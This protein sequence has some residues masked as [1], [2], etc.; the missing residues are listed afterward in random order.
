MNL[1][2]ILEIN[3]EAINRIFKI[4]SSNLSCSITFLRVEAPSGKQWK[5][6]LPALEWERNDVEGGEGSNNKRRVV[7]GKFVH[8]K[9]Y[10]TLKIEPSTRNSL[11]RALEKFIASCGI[12]LRTK[13]LSRLM[14]LSVCPRKRKFPPWK[15]SLYSSPFL[16]SCS[17]EL[18]DLLKVI[19]WI[20]Y[21]TET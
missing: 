9:S 13:A 19:R 12:S 1:N 18:A 7:A 6:S 14:F 21:F 3:L 5:F 15:F 11:K 20:Y 16:C 2:K 10:P 4:S 8:N 17:W